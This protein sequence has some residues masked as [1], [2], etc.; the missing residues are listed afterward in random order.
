MPDN[1]CGDAGPQ[2]VRRPEA[3]RADVGYAKHQAGMRISRLAP[4]LNEEGEEAQHDQRVRKGVVGEAE[5]DAQ[6]S[7]SGLAAP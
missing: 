2:N 3:K 6:H 1:C 7:S 4:H 5:A